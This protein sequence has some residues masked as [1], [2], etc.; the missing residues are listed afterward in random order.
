MENISKL[1]GKPVISIYN[2]NL[3]GYVKNVLVDKKIEKIC[4]LEVF[5][6]E[7]Q[8]EKIVNLKNLYNLQ[9]DAIMIKNNELI[10]I[11]DT[12]STDCINPIGYKVFELDGTYY[13]K[14]TDLEYDEKLNI[15]K[16]LLQ[17]DKTLNLKNILNVGNEIVIKKNNNIKLF[18]FKPKTKIQTIGVADN[19]IVKIQNED[20]KQ[21]KTHPKK[22]LTPNYSFLIGRKVVKDIFAENKQILIK[23]NV[24]ID[25][26]IIKIASKNGK[27][28]E[29]T[30]YSV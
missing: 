17:N 16:I 7:T 4:W 25:S 29:L 26:N 23:R 28:K 12:L 5:D 9:S 1:L 30:S 21:I 15:T 27:L 14:I 6:D 22:L 20:K 8:E 3:E 13:N 19:Q 11:A 24:K 2:G 10:Y 18:Q